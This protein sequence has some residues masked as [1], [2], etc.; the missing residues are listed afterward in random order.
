MKIIPGQLYLPWISNVQ[1][2]EHEFTDIKS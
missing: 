2:I 1:I